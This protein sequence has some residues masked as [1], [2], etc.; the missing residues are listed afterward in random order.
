[1]T[2]QEFVTPDNLEDVGLAAAD[3]G[4][5]ISVHLYLFKHYSTDLG[6][7][8]VTAADLLVRRGW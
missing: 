7:F 6:W 2:W 1:M 3:A 4:A 5:N 8:N